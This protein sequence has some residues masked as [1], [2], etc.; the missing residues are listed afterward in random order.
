MVSALD[1]IHAAAEKAGRYDRRVTTGLG[2]TTTLVC[3]D[4]ANSLFAASKF[5]RFGVLIED[6][7]CAGEVGTITDAGLAKSTGTLTIGDAFS[8]AIASG[9]TFSLY[10]ADRLLPFREGS[11]PSWLE[12]L[13]QALL[14]Q[15]VE[16]TLTIPGVTSQ[17]HYTIDQAV[18]PWFT[19]DTRIIEVQYPVT[20][21]DDVP[22]TVPRAAWSWV[23]DGETRRL[24][25][26]GA[27]FKTGESF[28]LKVNR[29]ANTRLIRNA[30]LRAVLSTAT[31]GSVTVVAGGYYSAVPTVAASGGGGSGAAFTAVL[32]GGTSGAITG[33]TVTNAGSGYTSVPTLTVTRGAADA[34]WA[35]TTSQ[36]GGL[37]TLSDEAIP[38]VRLIGA[39]MCALAFEALAEMGA[40]GQTV[41]EWQA[42]AALWTSRA[43]SLKS[44]RAPR[45][46][47]EGIKQLRPVALGGSRRRWR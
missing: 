22:T 26:P 46:A 20:N 28:T 4:Y 45:D 14:R 44:T 17:I 38:D 27:P 6:G 39:A 7:A 3:A 32:S 23:S 5:A 42:K 9:V 1:Y 21:A 37:V 15:W 18:W 13:N 16:D 19:D 10:D 25:F 43:V 35:D 36:T 34:G 41:A 33:V 2:T 8:S 29:P 12:I 40:S 31:V 11:K 30:A 47:N 24:R